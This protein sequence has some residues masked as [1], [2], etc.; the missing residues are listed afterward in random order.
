MVGWTKQEVEMAPITTSLGRARWTVLGIAVV[1]LL[2][3]CGNDDPGTT[4]PGAGTTLNVLAGISDQQ[5]PNIAVLAYLP[6]SI[7]IAPGA[8]VEWRIPGPER[9]SVTFL[10]PGQTVASTPEAALFEPAPPAGP[11]DGKSFVS[12]G[13]LPQAAVAAPPFR[14]TFPSVGE[15]TY[16]CVI[17]PSMTGKV[18][19]VEGKAAKVDTQTNL[20]TRADAELTTYLTEGRDAK[21]K[22]EDTP[23]TMTKNPDG[24]TSW[25]FA[26]GASTAHTAVLAFAPAQGEIRPKDQVTFLN[27]SAA[28]HTATFASGAQVPVDPTTPAARNATAPSPLTVTPTGGPFNSGTLPGNV[29]PGTVPETARSFTFVLPTAGEYAYVCIP[30]AQS[31][32]VGTIKVA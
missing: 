22:L 15:F 20:D 32:M 23:P 25:R 30:H 17:H 7:S 21:K 27:D 1:T 4:T 13:L 26:M 8:T 19:V 6:E 24:T 3:G 28:P 14:L 16:V 31:G 12:S 18:A 9:H 11:Y 29:P 2:A 5:D 10:P